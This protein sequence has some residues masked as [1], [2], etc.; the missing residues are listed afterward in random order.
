MKITNAQFNSY[1]ESS[2][3]RGYTLLGL[4]A[5]A[6]IIM[7][8]ATV[9]APSI[10]QQAQREREEEAIFRGEQV[11]EAIR[12]YI[13]LGNAQP[14]SIEQLQE[15]V[16]IVGRTRK[17]QVLRAS[18]ARDPLSSTREW[19][20]VLS[21]GDRQLSDFAARVTSYNNGVPPQTTDKNP[22]FVT[23]LGSLF[24]V[25]HTDDSDTISPNDED[26]SANPTGPIIGVASRSR[27]QSIIN[28]YGISRH[29]RWVFTPLFK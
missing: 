23:I 16:A 19:K 14:R 8:F 11:A 13:T 17:L 22:N 1:C 26:M 24:V 7:I 4:I 28:Y 5:L 6:T 2:D 27:R 15:G 18:A 21:T 3:E 29:D 20:M 10:K 12:T 9:A 25:T